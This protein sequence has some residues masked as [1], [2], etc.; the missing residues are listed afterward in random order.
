MLQHDRRNLPR[1]FRG[2]RR[3]RW[4]LD[5]I[6]VPELPWW[7]T[8]EDY[9]RPASNGGPTMPAASGSDVEDVPDPNP[10]VTKPPPAP[11]C[12]VMSAVCRTGT[13]STSGHGSLSGPSC[14]QCKRRKLDPKMTCAGKKMVRGKPCKLVYCKPCVEKQ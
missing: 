5:Y 7:L 10:S 12:A 2:D 4:G 8:R 13:A 6:K 3:R 1:P 11:P 9:T 14:H